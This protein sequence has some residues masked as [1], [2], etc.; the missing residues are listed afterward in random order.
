LYETRMA[1]A[2]EFI[3]SLHY[4]PEAGWTLSAFSVLR[5]GKLTAGPD[6][7]VERA[8]H[9]GQDVL[10]CLSG[11]G[12]VETLGLELEVQPGQLVWI[13]NE[14]PHAHRAN[15]RA[16]WTLLWLRLDGPN[17]ATLRKKLFGDSAPRVA[18]PESANLS[19]WFER[20]F[21]AMRRRELGLDLRLNHLVG[22]FL[23]IVDRALSAPDA[24]GAPQALSAIVAG[25]RRNLRRRW[26]A[27]EIEA[28]TDI[29]PSQIRRLFR[30]HLRAS[31]RQWLQRERLIHAQSLITRSDA[32]L[33]EIADTCGFCDVYHFSREF[34]R[35]VGISP[36]AWRR[37]EL[38]A[39]NR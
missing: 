12:A 22:E 3:E 7:G 1:A 16:P 30:R 33:A 15:P 34:K 19:A 31:P 11:A 25:M 8:S 10:Y 23:V 6:Y 35:A 37:V 2:T 29:S 17:P 39:K 13:A 32:P 26:S 24:A 27:K 20:L 36:A 14:A 21:L 28:L 38:G 5:A 4:V 18:M 9:V